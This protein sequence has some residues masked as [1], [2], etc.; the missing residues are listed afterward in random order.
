[1]DDE[2]E[3]VSLR[4]TRKRDRPC[5]FM[6]RDILE[7]NFP[8]SEDFSSTEKKLITTKG[9]AVADI[10]RLPEERDDMS[11]DPETTNRTSTAAS[12]A[13][14]ASPRKPPRLPELP[15]WIFCTR[16]SDRPSSGEKERIRRAVD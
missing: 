1:M 8:R 14:P 3:A 15:A 4:R 7:E 11:N 10:L 5:K 16:Y 9:F 6:I 2:A 12:S 13:M